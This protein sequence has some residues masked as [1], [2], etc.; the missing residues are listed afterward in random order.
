MSMSICLL[1]IFTYPTDT[2]VT[3][4]RTDRQPN[5]RR[6]IRSQIFS[7]ETYT[8]DDRCIP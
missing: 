8:H 3:L 5:S 2:N 1:K 4:P 6:K 7:D